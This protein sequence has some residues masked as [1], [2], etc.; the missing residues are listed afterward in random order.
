MTKQLRGLTMLAGAALLALPLAFLGRPAVAETIVLKKAD[1]GAATQTRTKRSKWW[2]D[3]VEKRS[4]GKVK[5]EFYP[6]SSP[7]KARDIYEGTRS[8]AVD[9][10]IWVQAYN[11]S[12]SPMSGLFF[13]PGISKQ[14]GPALRAVSELIFGPDFTFYRDEMRKTGVEPLYAW[15]VS[16][17]ELISTK[18]VGGLAALKGLKVRVIGRAWP[19]LISEFGGTPA[20]LPWPQVYEGL[21]R[22]TL[23]ANVGFVTANVSAK[24]HEVAKH[25]TRIYLGAPAGPVAIMNKK[26]WDGLPDDVKKIIR[27]VSRE[28]TERLAEDYAK[29]L[30]AAMATMKASGVKFYKWPPAERAK[31]GASMRAMW[32]AWA[33][34]MEAKGMP[35]REALRR[36]QELLKKHAG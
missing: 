10:G 1:F 27:Q 7:L 20:A 28:F 5:I 21:S 17:Q 13:L 3:E 22:G 33:D 19:K 15:G 23:D 4:G 11:P 9:I 29:D 35:G 14:I 6:A 12:V 25:H 2:S 24:L 32:D 18:P 16:D 31:L 26:K 8:G 36:Y 34:G 30:A